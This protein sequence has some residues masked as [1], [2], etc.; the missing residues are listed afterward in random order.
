MNNYE[1]II[2]LL[3]LAGAGILL[4]SLLL[5]RK[6]IK[7]IKDLRATNDQTLPKLIVARQILILLFLFGYFAIFF[8]F[9]FNI[10]LWLKLIT[11]IVFFFG[12]LYVYL[13]TFFNKKILKAIKQNY[14]VSYELNKDLLEEQKALLAGEKKYRS[15]L[16]NIDDS[17]FEVDLNGNLMFF[18]DSTCRIL[19][20][21]REKLMGMNYR[22]YISTE[23]ADLA[24][25]AYSNLL[26][27][28]SER[29][30]IEYD[31]I[32]NTGNIKSLDTS[33]TLLYDSD[34]EPAG[35]SGLARDITEK[36]EAEKKHKILEKQILQAQKLEAIGHLA[37]GIA[38][39]FNNILTA[40]TGNTK[41]LMMD[42]K[43]IGEKNK[44][45]LT[46]I[47]EATGRAGT[48]INQVLTF[49]RQK[50]ETLYPVRFDLILKEAIRF[51]RSTTSTSIEIKTSINA[52]NYHI[53]ADSTQIHQVIMNLCTNAKYAME[54]HNK[55]TIDISLAPVELD[56][57][58]GI[59]GN[60]LNGTFFELCVSDTGGG[61]AP[62]VLDKIFN[63]FFTTKSESKGTGLGLST[64]HGIVKSYG[65][66]ITVESVIGKGT[67]FKIYFPVTDKAEYKK[68]AAAVNK[69]HGQ[70]N[71]LLLDDESWITE[72]FGELFS[73][74]GYN[75]DVF[76]S[77]EEALKAVNENSKHYDVVVTDFQMP[78]MN[79]LEFAEKVKN[80]NN[81]IAIIISS[82]N[83]SSIPEKSAKK[84]EL[85][86]IVQK[87]FDDDKLA[88]IIQEA[89]NNKS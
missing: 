11:G 15:I 71:I 65:G 74:Y 27:K 33:I 73:D 36:K 1:I 28:K 84:I 5:F 75:V 23:S 24:Y 26:K 2:S 86:A 13:E 32:T 21:A 25:N 78:K 22:T 46:N 29:A 43:A 14:V 60:L 61:I 70:G 54:D 37:G 12:A 10:S 50:E 20:Y 40:I 77:S 16:E 82:G 57:F 34:G 56:D 49:S 45:N 88:E 17:Y 38:H 4:F 42:E 68:K 83:I 85:H 69:V 62:N 48:L 80:I 6:N 66:D 9:I 47:M 7:L 35:F 79:G 59:A 72:S 58:T 30:F 64:V 41:L 52:K 39:D 87:P 81:D 18:N 63:P 19:G 76:N 51:I 55:G 44:K 8:C 89:I 3:I 67:T 31:I 53:L